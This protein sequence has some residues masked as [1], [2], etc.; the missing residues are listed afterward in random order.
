MLS[1]C[2]TPTSKGIEVSILPIIPFE[3]VIKQ[4]DSVALVIFLFLMTAFA[5]T[6]KA[7]WDKHNIEKIEFKRHNNSPQS[8][9][10][11]TSHKA[12]NYRRAPC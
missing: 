3:V 6:V 4:G 1:P 9:G 11:I 10:Q 2:F 12:R 8:D 7:E 5:E